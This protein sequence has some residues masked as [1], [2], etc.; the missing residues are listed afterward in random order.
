MW[1]FASSR[2]NSIANAEADRLRVRAGGREELL[3]RV[4]A[5]VEDRLG[6]LLDVRFRLLDAALRVEVPETHAVVV[7]WWRIWRILVREGRKG[8]E[9]GEGGSVLKT[10]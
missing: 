4:E 1:E 9:L 3:R 10:I 2:T 8:S 5:D 7:T 6:E